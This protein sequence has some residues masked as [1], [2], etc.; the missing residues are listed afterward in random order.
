MLFLILPVC[1]SAQNNNHSVVDL[2][3]EWIEN[4][5]Y[6]DGG[7]LIITQKGAEI[8]GRYLH[9]GLREANDFKYEK[10][11]LVLTGSVH[12][13]FVQGRILLKEH[14]KLLE[15]CDE[16]KP[17]FWSE[18]KLDINAANDTLQGYWQQHTTDFHTCEI[19]QRGSQEY[20]LKRL[21]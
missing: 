1:L 2:S 18:I 5:N 6:P 16:I 4:K 9:V 20:I 3:G 8:E 19:V 12:K 13:Q 10:G 14:H 11:E 7:V 21:K 17:G 15:E